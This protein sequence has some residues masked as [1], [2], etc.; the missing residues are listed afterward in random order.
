MSQPMKGLVRFIADLRNARERELEAKR[1]NQE[2]ANIRHNF[3]DSSLNGYQKKKYI[4]KLIYIYILGYDINFGHLES[5]SLISSNTYSEKQ[6]GYLAISILL[7]ENSEMMHLVINSIKKDLNAMNDYFTCLALNCIATVG[8]SAIS[9]ALSDDIFKLLISPTS[10]DFVRKKAALTILRLYRKDPKII[11]PLRADRIVALID[12]TSLGVATSVASLVCELVQDNPEQYKLA[13]SKVVRRL[14]NLI[15][16]NGCSEDY[17]YYNVPAPW[18]FVKLLRLLQFFS[19]SNDETLKQSLR[20]VITEIIQANSVQTKN[21]QQSNAQNAVLF[22]AINLAIHHDMDH[23]LMEQIVQILGHFLSSRE[24]NTRYLALGAMANLASRYEQVPISQHLII[25]IQSLRDRDISVRRKAIDL[26]YSICNA[27]NVR[28]IVNELLKYLQ[29]AD[30]SIRGEMVIRIAVLVEKYATEYQW[31]VD[32]SLKLLSIAGSH[33][34]EEVWQRVVQIVV[35]NETLQSYS[36][37]TILQYLKSSHCN[38][39]LIKVGGYLLGEYGHLIAEEPNSSPIEQ[40]LALHDKFSTC[41]SFTKG[42]LL[43][44]YIKF[45]NLFPEIRPQLIQVFEYNSKSIDSELQQRAYEYLNMTKDENTALLPVLWDEMPPFPERSSTLLTR[46]KTKRIGSSDNKI[47]WAPGSRRQRDSSGTGSE[48]KSNVPP[49][50]SSAVMDSIL[51]GFTG[52]AGLTATPTGA[53]GQA[54]PTTTMPVLKPLPPASRKASIVTKPSDFLTSGWEQNYRKL[55]IHPEGIFYEDSVIQIGLRSEYRRHLGCLILY[56]R[57][58]SGSSLQSL[59]VEINNPEEGNIQVSTKNFPDSTIKPEST[60]QQVIIIEAHKAFTESPTVK[61]TYLAGSLQVLNLKLP[62]ILEKFMDPADLSADNYFTKWNQIGAGELECQKVFKNR[63]LN[64]ISNSS[65][66]EH[67][68]HNHQ[69]QQQSHGPINDDK[70]MS[71]LNW[72]KIPDADKNSLNF[73]GAGI[74]HTSNGGNFGCLI[75]LEPKEDKSMY[76][77]TV[78]ATDSAISQI[79]A[80]NVSTLYQI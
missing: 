70:M 78:R 47:V 20:K 38:E 23:S 2:L 26:L 28:T 66:N 14:Q 51:P 39:N 62:V 49:E 11:D 74:I 64:T 6:I 24:T 80:K 55:I 69:Q 31:Y 25:I 42:L 3:K 54:A 75:R 7:N 30:F 41:S 72:S 19:P 40:F 13:Y 46:V 33:V 37:K 61:I 17:L 32:I 77:V 44:T 59:S 29:A 65:G 52:G 22:E 76:R 4:C 43:T 8:G 67:Y 9:D 56:F 71:S 45:V 21:I 60:T 50:I 16:E 18:F 15:F 79:L 5:I 1:V 63:S 48:N 36:V 10:Q 12:S 58:I 34:S 73:V 57:N 35:N 27:N 68:F 53:P